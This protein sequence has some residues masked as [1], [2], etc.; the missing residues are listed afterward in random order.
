MRDYVAKHYTGQ[1][2]KLFDEELTV[3]SGQHL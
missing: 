2:E 3:S 1:Q